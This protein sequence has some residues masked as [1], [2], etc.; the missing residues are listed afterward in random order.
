MPGWGT[1]ITDIAQR[2]KKI[3]KQLSHKVCV[4]PFPETRT[5]GHTVFPLT[6]SAPEPPREAVLVYTPL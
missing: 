6:D 3:I 5:Q 2:G 1:K 4:H